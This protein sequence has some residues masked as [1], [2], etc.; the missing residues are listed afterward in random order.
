MEKVIFKYDVCHI[1]S[2]QQHDKN[3]QQNKPKN[4]KTKNDKVNFHHLRNQMNAEKWA[5][6]DRAGFEPA[7]SASFCPRLAKAAFIPG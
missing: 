1:P 5:K 3:R 4:S 2:L 6:V 7:T